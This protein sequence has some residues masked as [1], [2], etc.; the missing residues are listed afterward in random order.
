MSIVINGRMKLRPERHGDAVTAAAEMA[1]TSRSEPGCRQYRL[2]E[3]LEDRSVLL[4]VE[5]WESDEA[6]EAHL[7]APHFRVF[8]KTL[9][10]VLDGDPELTRFEV[11]S[12]RPLFG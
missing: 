8:S 4:L 10:E 3:D 2:G 11:S 9:G 12:S 1:A 6:L 5:E 7:A